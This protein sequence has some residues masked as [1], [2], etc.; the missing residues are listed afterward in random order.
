MFAT[1]LRAEY[2]KDFFTFYSPIQ[3]PDNVDQDRFQLGKRLFEDKNLSGSKSV[4]CSSCHSREYYG[5]GYEVLP[6]GDN[7]H[8]FPRNAPSILNVSLNYLIGWKGFFRTVREHTN[9]VMQEPIEMGGDWP[10]ILDYLLTSPSYKTLFDQ[11]YQKSISEDEVLDAL[12]YF[13]ENLVSPAPFDRF[14]LGDEDALTKEQQQGFLLFDQLGCS[15]CHNGRQ[16]GGGVIQPFGVFEQYTERN[17]EVERYRVPS[18]RN[19]SKTA[20]YF[21]DGREPELTKAIQIIGKYQIGR[22]LNEEQTA[23]LAA[24]LESLTSDES[25]W[26]ELGEK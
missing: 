4:S 3:L 8:V 15:S 21:H 1:S 2:S 13:Q 18:L 16:L 14:L 5:A 25:L 26:G 19:V 12:S 22:D 20:P 17:V 7:G 11:V 23:L 10:T 24:F 9:I 6:R